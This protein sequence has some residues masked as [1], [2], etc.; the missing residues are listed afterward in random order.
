MF[1]ERFDNGINGNYLIL[2]NGQAVNAGYK[3][4]MLVENPINAFLK[5]GIVHTDG[6]EQY[7]YDITSKTSIYS[8]YEH[9]EM[10]RR[11]IGAFIS[12]IACGLE[13]CDEYLYIDMN[14]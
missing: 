13:A 6:K 3:S 12:A 8:L 1:V 14:V 4:R 5:T 10:D 2:E 7:V 11:F 9:T